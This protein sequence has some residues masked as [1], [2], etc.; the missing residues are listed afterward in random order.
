MAFSTP[1]VNKLA[2]LAAT[3]SGA[4]IPVSTAGQ[5]IGAALLLLVFL[6][7]TPSW[8]KSRNFFLQPFA[9]MGVMLGFYMA[10]G[11]LWT[12]SDAE[13]AWRFFWKMRAYYIIP[14]LLFIFSKD[15]LR[16]YVL[17]SFGILGLIVVLLSCI[18]AAFDY[19][20]YKGLPGDWFIFKTHTYHNFYAA[21]MASGLLSI[22]LTQR[23]TSAQSYIFFTLIAIAGFDILFLVTGRT[24][25]IAFLCM[26]SLILLMW[27]W[28][29]G[30]A[31][32]VGILLILAVIVPRFS[33]SFEDGV[34]QCRV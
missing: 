21:L 11:T 27:N 26:L 13:A 6:L 4:A 34:C 25:Q 17:V 33:P 14:L 10:L 23:L 8:Q 5:N 15:F 31:M 18:S 32:L 16:N 19:P 30:F 3:L 29:R 2:I 28:R 7:S 24:G 9:V 12:S 22:V 1:D 20:I